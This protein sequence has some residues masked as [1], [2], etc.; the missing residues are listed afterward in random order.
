MPGNELRKAAILLMSLPEEDAADLLSRLDQSAVE[1]VSIE[2][3]KLTS[4]SQEEQDNTIVEFADTG[5]RS[6][7]GGGGLNLAQG[8]IEQAL[9]DKAGAALDN[10]KKSIEAMPFGFLHRVDSQNLLTILADEHPQ[11]IALVLSHL[12]PSLSAEI[13]KGLPSDQQLSVVQRIATMGQTSPEIIAEVES[14]MKQR[15]ASYL[16]QQFDSVGGVNSVAEML[17]VTDRATERAVLDNLSQ[18]DPRF[19]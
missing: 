11:T 9:G 4:V 15:T 7:V 10:V 6:T 8:L 18:D 13:I 17:N 3:A 5:S 1:A 16:N 2:L 12:P 19:G 14:A